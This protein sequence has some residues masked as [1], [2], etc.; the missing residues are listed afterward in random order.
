MWER[1]TLRRSQPRTGSPETSRLNPQ[2]REKMLKVTRRQ[3]DANPNHGET[4]PPTCQNG[5]HQKDHRQQVRARMWEPWWGGEWTLV[6]P[7]WRT[8]WRSLKKKRKMDQPHD[9]AIPR[10]VFIRRKGNQDLETSAP[11]VPAPLLTAA[12]AGNGLTLVSRCTGTENWMCAHAR[13]VSQPLR[14]RGT[15]LQA[16]CCEK[17]SQGK[18][19]MR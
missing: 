8:V 13:G 14:K 4:L 5:R 17:G 10:L 6:Q 3:G 16:S 7:L 19:S 15:C 2:V 1:L 18:K 12:K 9:S 11:H